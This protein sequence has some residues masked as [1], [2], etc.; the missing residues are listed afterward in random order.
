MLRPRALTYSQQC[1]SPTASAG[2]YG[3]PLVCRAMVFA[4][5]FGH[6]GGTVC[7]YSANSRICSFR[8][9]FLA[10]ALTPNAIGNGY[11]GGDGDWLGLL[12]LHLLSRPESRAGAQP[13]SAWYGMGC[14]ALRAAPTGRC[15]HPPRTRTS[16]TSLSLALPLPCVSQAPCPL[17]RRPAVWQTPSRML[18]SSCH[19]PR[20]CW[21][22]ACSSTDA[23]R[24]RRC[25]LPGACC[26][27]LAAAAL[28][29]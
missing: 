5:C 1:L 7:L 22:P 10:G 2:K 15:R 20:S 21:C 14:R 16:L 18:R 8:H 17:N 25:M 23:A 29:T 9:R 11:V 3:R 12:L 6:R 24:A 26:P 27:Q 4:D 28:H 13:D 19:C